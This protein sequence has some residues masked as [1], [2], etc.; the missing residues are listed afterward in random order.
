MHFTTAHPFRAIDLLEELL[1]ERRPD[2]PRIHLN[3]DEN[4]IVVQAPLPGLG[5]DRLGRSGTYYLG[6][7]A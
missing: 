7:R 6:Q 1:H 3:E 4:Q 2:R 5:R